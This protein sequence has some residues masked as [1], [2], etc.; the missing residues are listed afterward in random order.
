MQKGEEAAKMSGIA[1]DDNNGKRRD[2][3][4]CVGLAGSFLSCY[5]DIA[6]QNLPRY[7]M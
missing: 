6:C 1:L 3:E 2:C 7:E 5:L 4:W